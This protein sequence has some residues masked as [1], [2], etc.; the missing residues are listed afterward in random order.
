[1]MNPE[2]NRGFFVDQSTGEISIE[3]P[4]G[5]GIRAP[6][7]NISGMSAPID[8]SLPSFS[9]IT[10]ALSD[11]GSAIK[12][13]GTNPYRAEAERRRTTSGNVFRPSN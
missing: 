7:A 4:G 10:D 1:V 6:V 8:F 2:A 5:D 11:A 12:S 13:L 3:L 9:D